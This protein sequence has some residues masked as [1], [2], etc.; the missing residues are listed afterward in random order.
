VRGRGASSGTTRSGRRLAARGRVVTTN[1]GRLSAS[2]GATCA[3]SSS[4]ARPR[5]RREA[6]ITCG[7][8]V[9]GATLP[10]AAAWTLPDGRADRGP[11]ST[12]VIVP[13][14][15]CNAAAATASVGPVGVIDRDP[16]TAARRSARLYD[17]LEGRA[18]RLRE[19]R[20]Q[21][22]RSSSAR[23]TTWSGRRAPWSSLSTCPHGVRGL[24]LHVRRR[25]R[26]RSPRRRARA[27]SSC[28]TRRPSATA[29]ARGGG[30][31]RTPDPGERRARDSGGDGGRAGRRGG[32]RAGV[33]TDAA[34]RV[35]KSA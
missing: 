1:T 9:D 16:Q 18:D 25:R 8:Y 20:A 7:C 31:G 32:R 21:R 5:S 4:R 34:N 6:S 22:T 30:G 33:P 19:G 23:T 10:N 3:R 11:S 24:R 29:A 28:W 2:T 14:D 12:T 17:R 27:R 35:R 13:A 15:V 26:G